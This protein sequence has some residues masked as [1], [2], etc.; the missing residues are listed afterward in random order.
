MAFILQT[1]V[2]Y[3]AWISALF[4]LYLTVLKFWFVY[5]TN[6][7]NYSECQSQANVFYLHC[8]AQL[9]TPVF[10]ILNDWQTKI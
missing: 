2:L 10:F 9:K 5:L 8:C 7:L 3:F 6:T 4:T 1:H